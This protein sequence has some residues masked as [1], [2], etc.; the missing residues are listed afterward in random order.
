MV[1]GSEAGSGGAADSCSDSWSAVAS[2]FTAGLDAGSWD[3]SPGLELAFDSPPGFKLR[4]IAWTVS[5]APV[6][7]SVVSGASPAFGPKS[8]GAAVVSGPGCRAS[9]WSGTPARTGRG[10]VP[11]SKLLCPS[12]WVSG[13]SSTPFISETSEGLAAILRWERGEGP[14]GEEGTAETV[15]NPGR[16]EDRFGVREEKGLSGLRPHRTKLL[17]SGPA[18]RCL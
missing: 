17:S 4:S 12:P 2:L 8:T 16:G 3:A 13:I 1:A 14:C 18:L 6:G 5:G 15:A 10:P 11:A 9:G 7:V